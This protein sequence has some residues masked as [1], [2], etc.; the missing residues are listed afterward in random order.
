MEYQPRWV[1]GREVGTG[2]RKASSRY[3]AIAARL[4]GHEQFTV[5]DVGAYNGYFSL[6]LA[7]D[8]DAR[9]TAA[10]TYRGLPRALAEAADDRVIGLV[11]R[12]TP[13][14]VRELGPFDVVLCLS[15]LHHAP[16]WRDLLDALHEQSRVLFVETAVPAE[17]LPKAAMHHESAA[18]VRAVEDLG[19]EIIARTH[20]Y[21]SKRQRPLR[22]IGSL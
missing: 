4:D 19:G 22:M 5:L 7:E 13:A 17:T 2:Q 6:R 16:D 11:E 3:E 14:R 20:G 8:F 21:K 15:V 12:I 10:D 9:C 18:I 1:D